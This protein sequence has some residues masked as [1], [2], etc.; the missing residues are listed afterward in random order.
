MLEKEATQARRVYAGNSWMALALR[1]GTFPDGS[2]IPGVT[3][4]EAR[5]NN[6]QFVEHHLHHWHISLW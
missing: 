5:P 6:L 2:A 3:R 4:W 1:D